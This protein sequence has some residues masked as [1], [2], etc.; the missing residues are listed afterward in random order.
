[1]IQVVGYLG[2]AGA[3]VM[4]IPQAVRAVR[5]RRHGSALAGISP[6]TYATAMAFNALLLTY[7]LLADA[8]PVV[9]AG[10]VNL[11]CATVIMTVVLRARGTAP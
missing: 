11:A 8:G 10:A 7:G 3:A 9:L 2:S 6:A 4:W 1:M 5:L